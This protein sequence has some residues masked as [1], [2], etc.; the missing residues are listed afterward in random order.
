MEIFNRYGWLFREQFVHDYGID[1]HV[2]MIEEGQTYPNGKLFALQIKSGTS[3]FEE[4]TATGIV[5]RAAEKHVR[6][7]LNHSM[8]VLL[9]LFNPDTDQL[10]WQQVNTETVESTGKGWKIV[11]P[12]SNVLDPARVPREFS[13]MWQ[14]EPYIRR[15]NRLRVDKQWMKLLA[16]D[17]EVVLEFDDWVNKSLPRFK[18]AITGGGQ[19][20]M[21]PTV[22][23]PGRRIEDVLKHYISWADYESD[24]EP[25]REYQESIWSAEC[26]MGHDRETGTTYYSMPFEE[27]YERPSGPLFAVPNEG[28]VNSYR[29]ILSLNDFGKAFLELDRFLEQASPLEVGTFTIDDLLTSLKS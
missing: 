26:Y 4:V 6:Y 15:L 2:E 21:W 7:W 13:K 1:A 9:L 17:K 23:A 16:E 12:Q 11:V 28:E 8:P 10:H 20:L 5:Y 14:P 22:Y 18:V 29:L 3:F 27:W 24:E 19:S 25:Y